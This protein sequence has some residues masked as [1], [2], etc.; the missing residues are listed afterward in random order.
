MS[1]TSSPLHP[2]HSLV[3]GP[4]VI[5]MYSTVHCRP[6][7][8]PGVPDP[9]VINIQGRARRPSEKEEGEEEV[10]DQWR[11]LFVF[12]W[13]VSLKGTQGGR[14]GENR[15]GQEGGRKG[16]GAGEKGRTHEGGSEGGRE[17]RRE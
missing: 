6:Q 3:M 10:L 1:S 11:S 7:E 2:A 13:I 16:V 4:T 15:E 12:W 9:P 17:G 8:G 5:N 14:K